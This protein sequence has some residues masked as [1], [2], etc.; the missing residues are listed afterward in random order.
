MI[1]K[2]YSFN[3]A[4]SLGEFLTR[5]KTNI[6]DAEKLT[7]GALDGFDNVHAL[8]SPRMFLQLM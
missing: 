3:C 8:E 1:D 4:N 7:V 6:F 2:L 5:A